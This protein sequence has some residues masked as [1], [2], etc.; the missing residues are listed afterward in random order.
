MSTPQ[1]EPA[2]RKLTGAVIPALAAASLAALAALFVVSNRAAE[3]P[4]ALPPGCV[5]GQFDNLGGP[6]SL[7]DVNGT[8]VTEADFSSSPAVV[9]FG[10]T[11][12]PDV[13]PTTLYTL[14]EALRTPDAPDVQPIMI[15]VDPE[16]D[17]PER[18]RDYVA[19]GGFPAGLAGLTGSPEEISSIAEGFGA[20]YRRAPTTADDA[21]DVANYNVDHTSFLYILAPGWRM[22]G[23]MLT[24]GAKPEDL[25]ACISSAL[26]Q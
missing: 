16:R 3:Q 23:Q 6:F 19:S 25:A 13:C 18:M 2:R 11:S 26:Q 5:I 1:L 9:Y 24:I 20:T 22:R 7:Q 10:F 21:S 17:T 8:P 4:A 15:S 14:A 12:C